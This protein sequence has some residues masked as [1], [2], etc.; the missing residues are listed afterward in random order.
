MP[1]LCPGIYLDTQTV[2]KIEACYDNCVLVH[3][4]KEIVLRLEVH[5]MTKIV[6]SHFRFI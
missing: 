5:L 6:L 4:C 2:I 3:L 1:K